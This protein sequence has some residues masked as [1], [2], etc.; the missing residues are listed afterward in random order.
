MLKVST[1]SVFITPIK[2]YLPCYICG[3]PLRDK[4]TDKVHDEL[5][6]TMLVLKINEN[7]LIWGE[8]DL[9]FLD[10][11]L[12]T[13]I[14]KILSEKYGIPYENI[15]L[16]A[17]HTHSGPELSDKNVFGV[18]NAVAVPGY[19][20]FVLNKC[21]EAVEQCYKKGFTEVTPYVQTLT[22]DALYGNRNGID[23][24]SDKSVTLIKFRDRQNNIIAG[25]VNM[26]CH[27]TV[28]DPLGMEISS[29]LF[30]YVSRGIQIR[31]GVSPLM[32]QGACGDM[33]N[34][35]YRQGADFNEIARVGD[36]ILK[37][38]DEKATP[39]EKAI[40]NT[41]KIDLYHYLDEY[42]RDEVSLSKIRL[43]LEEDE[44]KLE[45]EKN[46]DQRKLLLSGMAFMKQKINEIHVKNEYDASIIRLG[47]LEICQIPAEL[48]SCLGLKIK[49][50]SRAKYA[51]IWGYTN[52]SVGYLVENSE[53]DNCYEGR[54]TN[55][56]RGEPE[57][58]TRDLIA[59][60]SK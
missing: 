24:I 18:E 43:E 34:R 47:D 52:D 50:A 36:G 41:A 48:F 14:R 39:E 38:I 32:M 9:I 37:Q 7:V 42:D 15:T 21:L 51:I 4:M 56:R 26:T 3:N 53:Y 2:S 23:K 27:P 58:M 6:C 40:F 57:R 22:I 54:S 13:K 1:E 16:G 10:L 29:D 46:F 12:S 45:N 30:G 55:I 28:N 59:L 8:F 11:E 49:A 19:K 25:C 31:W 20:D 35:Q 5:E 60:I 33:S 17:I 44:K